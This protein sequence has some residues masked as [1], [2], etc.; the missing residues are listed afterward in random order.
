[1]MRATAAAAVIYILTCLVLGVMTGHRGR[2]LV[3]KGGAIP[4]SGPQQSAPMPLPDQPFD[5]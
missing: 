2:S 5:F 3:S 4:A 1:L